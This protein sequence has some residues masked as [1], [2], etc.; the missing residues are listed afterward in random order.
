MGYTLLVDGK[1]DSY[2]L[3]IVIINC[4]SEIVYH[5]SVMTIINKSG[6]VEVI[7]NIVV[8]YHKFLESIISNIFSLL[9]NK[10]WVLLYYFFDIR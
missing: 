8:K 4:L 2:D 5:K 9:T 6:L 10:F 1:S 3:T 7:I